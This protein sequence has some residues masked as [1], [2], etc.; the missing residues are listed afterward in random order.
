MNFSKKIFL[1]LIFLIYTYVAIY[2]QERDIPFESD[3]IANYKINVKLN[4]KTKIISGK[5]IL[6]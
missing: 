3:R 2:A 1:S 5:I 6:D 4:P